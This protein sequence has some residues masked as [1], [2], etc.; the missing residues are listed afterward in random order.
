MSLYETSPV[1]PVE[2][3]RWGL[4]AERH[5]NSDNWPVAVYTPHVAD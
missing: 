5:K 4:E 3:H 2:S 1:D